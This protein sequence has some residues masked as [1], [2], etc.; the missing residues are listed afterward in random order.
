MT[1]AP[2]TADPLQ[3]IL[4]GELVLDPP[5]DPDAVAFDLENGDPVQLLF[6]FDSALQNGMTSIETIEFQ[7]NGQDFLLP[8]DQTL[9]NS[10]LSVSQ[11]EFSIDGLTNSLSGNLN[12]VDLNLFVFT[13]FPLVANFSTDVIDADT[14]PFPVDLEFSDINSSAS[15]VFQLTTGGFGNADGA[16]FTVNFTDLTVTTIPEPAT[17]VFALMGFVGATVARRRRR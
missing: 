6:N 16:L 13:A 11:G 5:T 3:L 4:E 15:G 7:I 12:G 10:F 9:A 2:A 14:A 8:A 1:T 17:A